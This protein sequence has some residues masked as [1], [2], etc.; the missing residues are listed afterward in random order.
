MTFV[1][2]LAVLASV[3]SAAAEDPSTSLREEV[4]A[5]ERAF[6]KTMADRDHE[7]FIS[8]LAADSV[9]L[10][11][12]NTLR[13]IEEI[14][15]AWKKRYEGPDAPFSWAPERVEVLDSGTLAISTGPVMD[16]SGKRIGTFVSTWR[17]EP[18]GEW[19]VVL[20]TGCSCSEE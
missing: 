3:A 7:A 4:L 9:F 17:R 11:S 12:G 13:G 2:V 5:A 6:A 19:K 10:S 1:L 20:D 14:A 8:F 16:P 18:D 15:G